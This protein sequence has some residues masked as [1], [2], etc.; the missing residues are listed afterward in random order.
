M[1]R[2]LTLQKGGAALAWAIL[3]FA[4]LL[5]ATGWSFS[6][7]ANANLLERSQA[8]TP[9]ERIRRVENGL[10]PPAI[11][12]GESPTLMKLEDRMRF[13]KTP[14]LSLA[15]INNGEIEWARSYGV[16]E[17]GGTSPVVI[18]TMFQ[19]ASISKP[20]AAMA[21][22]RLVQDR[23]LKLDED[24][25]TRLKSW[26][27]PENEFTKDQKV[28]LRRLL[29]HSAGTTVSGFLGY[30]ADLQRPTLLQILEGEKPA[31]SVPIRVDM[32][33]GSKFRYSGGGYVVL[34]QLL[35]D[36]SGSPF[37]QL[38]NKSVLRKLQMNHS[39]F[40][41][42]LAASDGASVASGH[43]P[44]GKAIPGRWYT[45]PEVAPAGLWTTPSDLARFVIEIQKSHQ[46]K[47][48]KVLSKQMIDQMLT[49]QVENSALGL[50]VDGEGR[51][52]R[53]SFSGSNVGF[54]CYMVGYLNAGQGAVVMTN[55]E[56]GAQLVLE[57]LR[58]I[59]AAYGWPDYRP[60]EKVIARVDP[61]IYDAYVGKYE[62][63]P[64]FIL[65]VTREENTLMNEAP[66]QPKS[67][68]FPESETTFFVKNADAQFTFV[69]DDKGNVVQ[70][71]IRR[72]TRE[73]KGRKVK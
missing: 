26:K 35:V 63:A 70:V 2:R 50:F 38:M 43:L 54:K 3:L 22:L 16:V 55:S 41:Q 68:M 57:V 65:T 29:S 56:T 67:E 13:Y 64:G 18:D 72:G 24:I 9:E 20:V 14:G 5:A 47:S 10:L 17:V 21:A 25:N 71:N 28:T 51:S 42:P 58:S 44:D 37:E 15:I 11:V 6:K 39:T 32:V 8:E 48:N 53:F 30:T 49:P 45:Y 34:Q 7:A 12:K 73:L 23:K 1:K 69:K 19:A 31:N 52:A 60:R 61:S 46:G 4:G 27:L 33:P 66:G 36:T 40:A 62:I 59:S